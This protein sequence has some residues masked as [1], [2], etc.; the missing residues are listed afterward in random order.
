MAEPPA[1]PTIIQ[2]SFHI[3]PLNGNDSNN[4]ILVGE[5]GTGTTLN[6]QAGTGPKRTLASVL[7][8]IE[9]GQYAQGD[10][11]YLWDTGSHLTGQFRRTNGLGSTRAWSRTTFN[12]DPYAKDPDVLE[13]RS[14]PGEEATIST[15]GA[16]PSHESGS[17]YGVI[18]CL[19]NIRFSGFNLECG[20]SIFFFGGT[21]TG[22]GPAAGSHIYRCRQTQIF[23]SGQRPFGNQKG[24]LSFEQGNAQ[25]VT[26]QE[27]RFI[28]HNSGSA[29][30]CTVY[31]DRCGND[32]LLIDTY[33]ANGPSSAGSPLHMKYAGAARSLDDWLFQ[34]CMLTTLT[35]TRVCRDAD[36]FS[37]AT[38]RDCIV[39]EQGDSTF[40]F[41]D[42]LPTGGS[43]IGPQAY[44][45]RYYNCGLYR[46]DGL[47]NRKTFWV[48]DDGA[49]PLQGTAWEIFRSI[50]MGRFHLETNVGAAYA[51]NFVG[52]Q[53]IWDVASSQTHQRGSTLTTL[54][55]WQ[56][57]Q[58]GQGAGND[59]ANSEVADVVF[60]SP[61]SQD[62]DDPTTFELDP[63]MPL[64]GV[65]GPRINQWRRWQGS[66]EG[67]W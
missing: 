67:A 42:T 30:D 6:G 37:G 55:Q 33:I 18:I 60:A 9:S 4:G 57:L 21:G 52:D 3:D 58:S 49:D 38:F 11:F 40:A 63:G 46:A 12:S 17:G 10:L 54:A 34:R 48:V 61:G 39:W 50:F 14:R 16:S 13:F 15:A 1:G 36:G 24:I 44:Q 64:F 53:N 41:G 65:A 45:L 7:A 66:G 32:N 35:S 5:T 25:G 28:G 51:E 47:T 22:A 29:N 2:G 56:S 8:A 20:N 26:I 43:S 27:C 62:P 23:T 31:F 59:D 19:G